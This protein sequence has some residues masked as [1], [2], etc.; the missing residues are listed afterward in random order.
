MATLTTAPPAQGNDISGRD[1]VPPRTGGRDWSDFDL[2]EVRLR[3]ARLG[4]V[5]GI[6]GIVMFFISFTSA[7]IVRKGLPTFDPRA[8]ILVYDWYSVPLPALLLINSLV[9]LISTITMELA[10]RQSARDLAAAQ[11]APITKISS[12]SD[13]RISWLAL[14]TVLG[15][16][17]LTGQLLV[18]RQLAANGF[19]VGTTPSSS[20]LYLLTA[21]HGV[22]LLGGV[23]ALLV[24]GA[25]SLL[26]KPATTQFVLVD[27]TGWYW[28]FMAVL[29][30]YILCLFEFVR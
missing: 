12:K 20:F 5:V 15:F 7:Y 23:I 16:S 1:S 24:A 3:R 27:V 2:F 8:N 9:L 14:T 21:A 10:R 29:W 30:I 6:I 28:H 11:L 4:L 13:S 19:Y 25:A 17:F 18:W 26:R 22:H